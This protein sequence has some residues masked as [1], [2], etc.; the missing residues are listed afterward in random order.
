[1]APA[2][3]RRS[4]GFNPVAFAAPAAFTFGNVG[5]N[6]LVGPGM[7]TLDLALARDFG[8]TERMKFQFSRRVSSML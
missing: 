6:T 1:L 8:L 5:R 4:T 7:Q 2:R 3:T